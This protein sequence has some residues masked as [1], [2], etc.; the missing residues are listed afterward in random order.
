MDKIRSKQVFQALNL[1]TAAFAIVNKAEYQAG[2]AAKV[3]TAIR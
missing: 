3:L 2:D 1:P